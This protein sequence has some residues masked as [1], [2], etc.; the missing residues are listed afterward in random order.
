M[1]EM[2]DITSTY[3]DGMA[4]FVSGNYGT[5]VDLFS[6]VLANDPDHTRALTAR[7]AANLK[8]NAFDEAISDFNRAIETQPDYARAY[9]LRGL[10]REK[11]GDHQGAVEDFGRAIELAPEYGAAYLSRA[12]LRTK[13]GLED[14]A[15]ED[16]A[17]I[18][19][20]T[21]RNIETFANENNIWRSQQ[22]RVETMLDTDL[23]R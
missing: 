22:L 4:E 12:T 6:E 11:T 5:S 13:M 7:G 3:T 8:L 16:M 17:M 21:N 2:K 20:L 10:A 14:L 9:H 15:A 1:N 18:T 19:H 23:N